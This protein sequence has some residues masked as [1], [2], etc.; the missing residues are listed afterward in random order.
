MVERFTTTLDCVDVG[1][2]PDATLDELPQ[3]SQI[4]ATHVGGAGARGDQ[5]RGG[6]V[7]AVF[8]RVASGAQPL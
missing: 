4:G 1:F 6:Q 2:I 3:P 7:P 8:D 5:Q